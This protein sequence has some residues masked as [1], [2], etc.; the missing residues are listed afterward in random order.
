MQTVLLFLTPLLTILSFCNPSWTTPFRRSLDR[1]VCCARIHNH[2]SPILASSPIPQ[3]PSL[4]CCGNVSSSLSLPTVSPLPLVIVL[5][6][7]AAPGLNPE[8]LELELSFV[9]IDAA[10]PLV[11]DAIVF[12]RDRRSKLLTLVP[13]GSFGGVDAGVI[14]VLDV[15][16][17]SS[18]SRYHLRRRVYLPQLSTPRLPFCHC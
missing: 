5:V 4:A 13:T 3:S 6:L 16:S 12:V 11:V 17:T 1:Y 8:L 15:I 10:F 14:S 7:F 2:S 9:S 18:A